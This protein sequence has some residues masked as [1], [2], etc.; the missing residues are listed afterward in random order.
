MQPASRTIQSDPP[1][2][3]SLPVSDCFQGGMRRNPSELETLQEEETKQGFMW[4]RIQ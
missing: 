4:H 3:N 1:S 2:F